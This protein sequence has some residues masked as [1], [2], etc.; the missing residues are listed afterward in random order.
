MLELLR[1]G[2]L[3]LIGRYLIHGSG[4]LSEASMANAGMPSPRY[5]FSV[6]I[7]MLSSFKSAVR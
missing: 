1:S 4:D 2:K 6:I 3:A 5:Y 7:Q